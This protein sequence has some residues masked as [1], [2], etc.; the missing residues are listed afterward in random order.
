MAAMARVESLLADFDHDGRVGSSEIQQIKDNLHQF[1]DID[2]SG[3][4]DTR[5]IKSV[6]LSIARARLLSSR[7]HA[8]APFVALDG[9]R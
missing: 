7:T 4:I 1:F 9:A 8:R 3:S 6:R 2:E 5:E